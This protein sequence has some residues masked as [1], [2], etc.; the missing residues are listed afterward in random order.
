MKLVHNP[1]GQALGSLNRFMMIAA[2]LCF[3]M[4]SVM[5][6]PSR[7]TRQTEVATN[8]KN[9]TAQ[10]CRSRRALRVWPKF[11]SSVPQ[12]PLNYCGLIM[13]DHGIFDLPETTWIHLF[14]TSRE[15]LHDGLVE[16]CSYKVAGTGIELEKGTAMSNRNRTFQS[17]VPFGDC[18]ILNEA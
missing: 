8:T 5:V 14:G 3:V 18:S 1:D 16:G 7:I 11:R 2:G 17:A 10:E 13:S 4:I 6:F 15:A 9:D 12:I